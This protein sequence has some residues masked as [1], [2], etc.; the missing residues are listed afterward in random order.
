[1]GKPQNQWSRPGRRRNTK[2]LDIETELGVVTSFGAHSVPTGVTPL[3]ELCHLP[4]PTE[5]SLCQDS[6]NYLRGFSSVAT[7]V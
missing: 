3:R 5:T 6:H 7:A 2:G 4:N 1:M